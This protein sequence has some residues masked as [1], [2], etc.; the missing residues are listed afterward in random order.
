MSLSLG[1]RD[2]G[3]VSC[4]KGQDTRGVNA[5]HPRIT[6]GSSLHPAGAEGTQVHMGS[7]Q[8][9]LQAAELHCQAARLC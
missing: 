4:A 3:A 8:D 2:A 1:R 7:E 6:S 9:L 5:Q